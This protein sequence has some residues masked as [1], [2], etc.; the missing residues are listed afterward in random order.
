MAAW[1]Q[2]IKRVMVVK[3]MAW[4]V[5]ALARIASHRCMAAGG[6]KWRSRNSKTA[7]AAKSGISMAA[8]SAG[9]AVSG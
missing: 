9:G 4:H 1:Q 7:A 5:A 8:S 6:E 2:W 3:Q